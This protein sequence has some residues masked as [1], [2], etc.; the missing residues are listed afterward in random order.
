LGNEPVLAAGEIVGKTTSAAFGYR[1]GR[2][3]A[4]A[5]VDA[6]LMAETASVSVEVDIAGQRFSGK[7]L[8][9]PCFDPEGTRMRSGSR[10]L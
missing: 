2:P 9:S 1:I 4:L 6:G 10:S 7:A 8:S 5:L 3:V